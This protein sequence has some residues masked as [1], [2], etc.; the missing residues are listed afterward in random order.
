M[1]SKMNTV[2]HVVQ[3]VIHQQSSGMS[4]W[5]E[6]K[7]DIFFLGIVLYTHAH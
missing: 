1:I 6:K 4:E 2:V 7:K 3:A 5:F